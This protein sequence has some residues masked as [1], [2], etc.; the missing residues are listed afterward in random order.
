MILLISM[1]ILFM[2]TVVA[3]STSKSSLMQAKMTAAVF[4]ANASLN[5][6]EAALFETADFIE[7]L[8]NVDGFGSGGNGLYAEDN[9]PADMFADATWAAGKYWTSTGIDGVTAQVFI[10]D[11]GIPNGSFDNTSIAQMGYGQTTGVGTVHIF[12]IV[13]RSLGPNGDS[14]RITMTYYG[15]RF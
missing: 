12:K 8:V 2:L 9:G 6:T 11:L 1:M 4:D 3:L 5:V 14:E 13:A 7:T 10:E 15:K